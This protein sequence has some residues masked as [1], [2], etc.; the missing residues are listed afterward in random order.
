V[1]ETPD[2]R[3]DVYAL[4]VVLFELLARRLPFE[5][6]TPVKQA[7]ARLTRP[8]PDVCEFCEN[9]PPP[10]AELL[11]SMLARDRRERPDARQVL[12]ALVQLRGEGRGAH[13]VAELAPVPSST[14]QILQQISRV[15]SVAVQPLDS[16]EPAL[17]AIGRGLGETLADGLAR[18]AAFRVI[19]PPFSAGATADLLLSGT[20][21][22]EGERLRI[23]LRYLDP[24]Q[25]LQRW[26]ERFE[27]QRGALFALEDTLQRAAEVALR[28]LAGAEDARGGATLDHLALQRPH[29]C[30]LDPTRGSGSRLLRAVAAPCHLLRVLALQH[31]GATLQHVYLA[32]HGAGRH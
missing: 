21:R 25:K 15:R 30:V 5:G 20:V 32:R 18:S 23:N 10:V 19:P 31:L 16:A 9:I 28:A 8:A 1:G 13:P 14:T 17:E 6:D 7:T 3:S 12:D 29:L 22:A 4:G 11:R 26:S 2:G 27:G 24:A